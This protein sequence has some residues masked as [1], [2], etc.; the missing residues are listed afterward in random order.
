MA[1]FVIIFTFAQGVNKKWLHVE[2]YI[3]ERDLS[4][5]SLQLDGHFWT[6]NS[7]PVLGEEEVE[8]KILMKKILNSLNVKYIGAMICE[9][10]MCGVVSAKTLNP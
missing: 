1:Y 9:R 10:T 2:E 4:V 5:Q 7:R 3:L 6:T 8:K